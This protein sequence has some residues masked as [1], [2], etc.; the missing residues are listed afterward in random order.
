M[1]SRVIAAICPR[2]LALSLLRTRGFSRILIS[3][4][5][6]LLARSEAERIYVQIF[7]YLNVLMG[8]LL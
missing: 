8:E 3:S 1:S 4:L 2:I 7:V 6:V 5:I